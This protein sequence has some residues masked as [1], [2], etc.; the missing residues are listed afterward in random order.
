[1]QVRRWDVGWAE[2]RYGAGRQD[3]HDA[4][5]G[6]ARGL[7]AAAMTKRALVAQAVDSG[8]TGSRPVS[9]S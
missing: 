9:G 2:R 7:V 6:V 3:P 1:M 8:H 4:Y 5:D